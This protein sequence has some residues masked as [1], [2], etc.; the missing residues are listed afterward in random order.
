M[1]SP[2][3]GCLSCCRRRTPLIYPLKLGQ[4]GLRSTAL[5]PGPD[6]GCGEEQAEA[7]A[8]SGGCVFLS[9]LAFEHLSPPSWSSEPRGYSAGLHANVLQL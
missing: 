9:L 4:T 6:D 2:E 7:G 5:L 8:G 3:L 1:A